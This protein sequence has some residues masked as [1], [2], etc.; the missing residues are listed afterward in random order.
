MNKEKEAFISGVLTFLNQ[1][2]TALNSR[3]IKAQGKRLDALEMVAVRVL[4]PPKPYGGGL[5][6]RGGGDYGKDTLKSIKD[7]LQVVLRW[8]MSGRDESEDLGEI[9]LNISIGKIKKWSLVVTPGALP[10]NRNP[11]VWKI[12]VGLGWSLHGMPGDCLKICQRCGKFLLQK[13]RRHKA[14]CSRFCAVRATDARRQ[15]TE[16]RTLQLKENQIRSYKKRLATIH[17]KQPDDIKFK[18]LPGR[19][20]KIWTI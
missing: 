11:H 7:E 6:L 17:G 14:Y 9:K 12:L 4:I 13:T 8:L 3:Q 1:D 18:L 2:L 5:M 15:G 10:V 16:K 19:K 20:R